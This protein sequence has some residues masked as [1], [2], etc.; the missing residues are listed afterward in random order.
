MSTH[1]SVWP[2]SSVGRQH[3]VQMHGLRPSWKTFHNL[4][5]YVIVKISQPDFQTVRKTKCMVK[6]ANKTGYYTIHG[7]KRITEACF[8][9]IFSHI[10]R[11][12]DPFKTQS[13][14]NLGSNGPRASEYTIRKKRFAFPR[15]IWDVPC[16]KKRITNRLDKGWNI[17]FVPAR[18]SFVK[19]SSVH[20]RN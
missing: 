1:C 7:L 16:Y 13:P 19:K 12:S 4:I 6:F 8:V 3:A 11:F 5:Y 2:R 14:G 9:P 18:I 10:D 17:W 15:E 20:M